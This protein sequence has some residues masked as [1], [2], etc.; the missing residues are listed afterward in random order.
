[1]QNH[2]S[3]RAKT[4]SPALSA[5]KADAGFSE[6]K[7]REHIHEFRTLVNIRLTDR[8]RDRVPE[9]LLQGPKDGLKPI[10]L[11]SQSI[12]FVTILPIFIDNRSYV[13]IN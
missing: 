2:L 3:I 11:A 4:L 13:L 10:F 12:F 1:M 6:Q 5:A 7:E 8:R 9:R